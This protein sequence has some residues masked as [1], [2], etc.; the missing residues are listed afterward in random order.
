MSELLNFVDLQHILVV[1]LLFFVFLAFGLVG[2]H[3]KWKNWAFLGL[4]GAFSGLSYAILVRG[5]KLMFW[6][7]RGD[8]VTIAAMYQMFAH[9]SL[10][11]DFAYTLLPPFYPPL[12]FQFF[13]LIGRF[14]DWNGV[15]IAKFAAFSVM[16]IFPICYYVIRRRLEKKSNKVYLL[17]SAILIVLAVH[18]NSMLIKPYELV[19]ASLIILW[20]IYLLQDWHA[21][22]FSLKQYIA[23]GVSGG[24]LFM[25]F[26]FWFFL[27]AISVAIYNL[28]STKKIAVVKYLELFIIGCLVLMVASPFWYPLANTYHQLGAE[29]FQLGFF[30]VDWIKTYAPM[31][32]F[33]FLGL[34]SLIGFIT[35]IIYR[36]RE[37]VRILLSMFVAGYVWQIMGMVTIL[38][39][40]SPLQETKG[41]HFWS[42]VIL[43][44][45]AA[46]GLAEL[47]EW[48][49]KKYPKHKATVKIVGLIILATQMPFGFFVDQ[50]V[51]QEVRTRASQLRPGIQEL[52]DFLSTQDLSQSMLTSGIPELHAFLPINSILY[53]NQH[54]SHPAG[55]FSE[56]YEYLRYASTLPSSEKFLQSI[57]TELGENIDLF[58]FHKGVKGYYPI[59]VLRDNFPHKISEEKILIP[60]AFFPSVHFDTLYENSSFIVLK[61]K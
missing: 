24:I 15:Q 21:Q 19:S 43:A 16:V 14:A 46:Y 57:P 2:I 34:V 38:F 48:T 52:I 55:N 1:K 20:T 26:Y 56:K 31:F 5:T 22:K 44:M 60:R 36:R 3:Y 45:A 47:W 12:F 35:L 58:V 23:Y 30:I 10:L 11:S 59:Y 4:F 7:L 6:G 37:H 9:G 27:A 39:F 50:P 61:K 42:G 25:M 8:E 29:N 32:S 51:V 18:W 40:A 13:G 28:F 53:F 17:L 41:F 33:S 54:N 49:T